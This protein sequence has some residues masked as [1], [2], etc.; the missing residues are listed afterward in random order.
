MS[1]TKESANSTTTITWVRG[2]RPSRLRPVCFRDALGSPCE[3]CQA[4][5]RPKNIPATNEIRPVKTSTGTSICAED[6][7]GTSFGAQA[8]KRYMSEKAKSAPSAP[9]AS[10]SW[11]LSVS[12]CAM[13]LRRLAPN[14]DRIAISRC[15]PAARARSKVPMFEHAIKSTRA[16][17]PIK[18]RSAGRN[19]P[20]M[21]SC[22]GTSLTPRSRFD[23]GYFCSR[24]LA[25]TVIPACACDKFTLASRRP[26]TENPRLPRAAISSRKS[27][28][29]E[30]IK[31]HSSVSGSG[32]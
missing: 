7:L 12:N 18:I 6:I 13:I 17:E 2:L 24:P 10:A 8:I 29:T 19:F 4:G 11:R 31:T 26:M 9:P 1:K 22:K 32:N 20:T 16:A 25:I 14:E 5:A 15:R 21:S 3:I 30:V 27:G 23:S 28:R